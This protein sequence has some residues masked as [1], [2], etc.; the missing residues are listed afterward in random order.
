MML[1]AR[2]KLDVEVVLHKYELT[3]WADADD[4]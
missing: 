4:Q 2:N 1:R 3:V